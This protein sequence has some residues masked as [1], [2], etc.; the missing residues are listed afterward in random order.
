[1]PLFYEY[2]N[3]NVEIIER[4]KMRKMTPVHKI[5]YRIPS[6]E[7]EKTVSKAYPQ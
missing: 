2:N 4:E 1:M 6:A 7:R 3:I 5:Q